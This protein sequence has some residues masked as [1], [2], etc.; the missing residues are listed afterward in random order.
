M[1]QPN[2]AQQQQK[3]NN[4]S[5]SNFVKKRNQNGDI[6]VSASKIKKRIRDVKRTLSK[7]TCL[8]VG[9]EADDILNFSLNRVNTYQLK[10][11]PSQKDVYVY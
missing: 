5:N 1:A 9:I 7:V 6:P 11:L 3:G 4:G 2:K 10:S 8:F